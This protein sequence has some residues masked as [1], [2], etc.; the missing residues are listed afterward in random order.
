MKF[1]FKPSPNYRD[2][3]STQSIIFELTLGL[4]VIY[5]FGL[6]NSFKLGSQYGINAIV[7]LIVSVVVSFLSEFAYA[8]LRKLDPIQFFKTS[9]PW[10]T[11]LILV[12][13]VPVNTSAYAVGAST[14][15]GVVF[16]KLVFGGFGQNIFNPAGVG[17]ALVFSSFSSAVVTDLV[18]SA[19]PTA[20][21][22]SAGWIMQADLFETFIAQFGG[23]T[24]MFLGNYPGTLGE[25]SALLIMLVGIVLIIRNVIDYRIPLVY[26]GTIFASATVIALVRNTGMYYPLF[27]ILTG[28]AMFGAFFMLTDPV[29]NPT[30]ITGRILFAM[31]SG[32]IT[33]L[34]RVLANL[35]EGVLFSILIMNMLTPAID[36]A[37]EG[38]Q[39]KK[40]KTN[41][42]A[43]IS[44]AVIGLVTIGFSSTTL[45]AK[46]IKIAGGTTDTLSLSF[47]E[48][49]K[50]KDDYAKYDAKIVRVEGN[51][52]T[53]EAK[54]YG[55]L[56][57]DASHFDYVK[58]VFEIVIEDQKVVSV[59]FVTFGDTPGIGDKV[60]D[61]YLSI[62]EGLS[63]E[64]EVDALS[65][66]T[67]TSKS[68]VAAVSLAL[69][70][71]GK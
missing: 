54:G 23:L 36:R 59:K 51:T 32:F 12:L 33:V 44:L 31:G 62:Y 9:F 47:S 57:G 55:L 11:P 45:E 22:A 43:V 7:L 40:L 27:H 68:V 8:K 71:A 61:T 14:F 50:V 1:V 24:N 38:N 17:R 19:T 35:P 13:M 37:L 42:M 2:K 21:F 58:N 10:V 67:F 69:Q 3:K 26:L 28:G 63:L 48:T 6:Y 4:L 34:I 29:T 56:E 25:T 66:A 70:E 41:M 46:E 20:S 64:D 16:A 65:S 15:I 49:M 53:V 30:S 60:D 39:I 18:T 5:V 52:Y